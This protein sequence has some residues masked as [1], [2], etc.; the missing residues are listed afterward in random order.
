LEEALLFLLVVCVPGSYV[1]G[2]IAGLFCG[3][4]TDD[5]DEQDMELNK[6]QFYYPKVQNWPF[7]KQKI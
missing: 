4:D 3:N 6:V 2:M 5:Y 1:L 7:E